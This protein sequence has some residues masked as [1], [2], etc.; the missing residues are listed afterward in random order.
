MKAIQEYNKKL[1]KKRKI[2]DRLSECP[3]T[4]ITAT[5]TV[6]RNMKKKTIDVLTHYK[7]VGIV[8]GCRSTSFSQDKFSLFNK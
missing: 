4:N 1:P 2:K 6:K 5:N 8:D 3:T 7:P